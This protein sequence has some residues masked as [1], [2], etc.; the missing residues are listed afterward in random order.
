MYQNK[1]IEL[2]FERQSGDSS[3]AGTASTAPPKKHTPS[4]RT[5]PAQR[6]LLLVIVDDKLEKADF[7]QKSRC[8]LAIS[9]TGVI[10]SIVDPT[11]KT[12]ERV[13]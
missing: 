3:T 5:L 8:Y 10:Q 13:I 2:S 12:T 7:Y 6:D 11:V 4:D 1:T 9:S